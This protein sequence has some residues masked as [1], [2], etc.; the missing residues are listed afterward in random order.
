MKL[1]WWT[2]CFPQTLL[3]FLLRIIFRAE[4]TQRAQSAD[5][6]I[7]TGHEWFSGGSF[8]P[9][10]L[11]HPHNVDALWHEYGHCRQSIYLGPLYLLA[12]GIPSVLR[13]LWSR[14]LQ[15]RGAAVRKIVAWYYSGYPE[16]WADRLGNV[17]RKK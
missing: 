13:N 1:L 16:R 6:Y 4:W 10:I 14:V 5:L 12:V 17:R 8:G 3:G 2:W 7:V 11:L 15:A 9:Y